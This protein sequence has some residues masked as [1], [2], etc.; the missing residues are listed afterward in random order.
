MSWL[1]EYVAAA[2]ERLGE[3]ER[4]ALWARGV[5]DEQIDLFKLGYVDRQAPI[6]ASQD[7]V[8]LS[9]GGDRLDAS[10]VLPLTNALGEIRG[11]QFRHVDREIRG[12]LTYFHEHAESVYFGLGPAVSAIWE[13]ETAFVVEGA[14]DVF[15]IQ[16][17]YPNVFAAL[18]LGTNEALARFLRL[19]AKVVWLG[20]DNDKDGK[21]ACEVFKTKYD[22]LDVRFLIPPRIKIANDKYTKDQN[23]LWQAWG[24]E[25]FRTYL[26]Q[27]T[28]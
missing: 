26:I 7:F 21:R 12:Y 18:T 2:H 9:R 28:A 6:G 11:L 22:Y 4:E 20:Y 25:R 17:V 24:D 14:F 16:R 10:F 8:R 13:T 15:P 1:D 5:S 3:R 19:F 23:E 27:Q